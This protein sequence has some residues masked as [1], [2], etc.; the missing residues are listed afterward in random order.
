MAALTRMT[1][2]TI[3]PL[4]V[5]DPATMADGLAVGAICADRNA[6]MMVHDAHRLT[7][8]LT[9]TP[10]TI[11]STSARR[12]QKVGQPWWRTAV[13]SVG[14]RQV[15]AVHVTKSGSAPCRLACTLRE[16]N[17]MPMAVSN[18]NTAHTEPNRKQRP[19]HQRRLKTG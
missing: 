4:S 19:S 14:P 7:A 6:S 10:I 9:M 3:V 16:M 17:H 18:A 12:S 13:A 1:A 8:R 5:A 11:A 15:M 2:P